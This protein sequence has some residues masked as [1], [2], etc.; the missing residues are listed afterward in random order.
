MNRT[1]DSDGFSKTR[2]ITDKSRIVKVIWADFV[3]FQLHRDNWY[4]IFFVYKI[5]RIEARQPRFL[6]TGVRQ[7]N[8]FS[9]I[10]KLTVTGLHRKTCD[11][12]VPTTCRSIRF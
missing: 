2:I 4:D 6:T 11:N 1:L 7:L 8:R 12:Q 3:D 9:N 10:L 5:V